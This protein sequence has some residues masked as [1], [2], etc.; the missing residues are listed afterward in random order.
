[1]LEGIRILDLTR[2]FPGPFASLRLQERGAE[3]IK[4]EEGV[5]FRSMSRGKPCVCVNLK[6]PAEREK[7]YALVST[8]DAL[9][10]SFRPGVTAK[11]GI[12]YPTLSKLNPRL[13]YV[14]VTGYGQ[15]GTYRAL[16]GHDLNYLAMSGVMDQLLDDGGKPIKPQIALADLVTGV[17]V[18][19]AVAMGLVKSSRSGQGAY[20]DL[21]MTDAMLSFMGLHI[22]NAAATGEI[23]GINDHGIGY[24][25]FET[26]DGRYVALCALE[27]KFFANFCRSA[28]CEELIEHQHT[29]ASANNPYYGKMISIIKS[30]SFE[31]W[32]EFSGRVDCCMSPV[33]HTDE[34]KDSTY[35]RER[36]F[37]EH[38]WGLDYAAAVL[39][40]KNG[41]LNYDKPFHR[42]G[43]DNE[44][45]LGK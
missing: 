28:C 2:Y 30:R 19:E 32:K 10:E 20:I 34:L 6:D 8:A 31:Q 38:K 24:G 22:S 23:H 14:S 40:E 27:E 18:S 26:S 13:V 5:I 29:P 16:A 41:F 15:T 35:V 12:D 21:S 39:P 44:K 25:I 9:I 3:V 37:I 45:Y 1:M 43:E 17:T 4:G 33:L 11:L 7:F 42:L 36:G